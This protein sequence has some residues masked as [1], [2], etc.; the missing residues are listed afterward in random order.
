[1]VIHCASISK[2]RE[3]EGRDLDLMA[4]VGGVPLGL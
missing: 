3:R 2:K 4:V 1:M